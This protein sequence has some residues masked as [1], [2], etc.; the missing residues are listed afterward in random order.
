MLFR[1]LSRHFHSCRM[2]LS[3]A[4]NAQN[5][6]SHYSNLEIAPGPLATRKRI[7]EQ[8]QRLAKQWHPDKNQ[9]KDAPQRF[10]QITESYQLLSNPERKQE[11]D[12][13]MAHMERSPRSRFDI[14]QYG[15]DGGSTTWMKSAKLAEE[16][17]FDHRAAAFEA[18]R[19]SMMGNERYRQRDP[20]KHFS[21]RRFSC[22]QFA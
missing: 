10:A 7:R 13:W 6:R 21:G 1:C 18:S 14:P 8:F 22:F 4:F 15:G 19:K 11:Y 12:D 2:R 5:P 16:D 17:Y 20:K 3:A 9:S